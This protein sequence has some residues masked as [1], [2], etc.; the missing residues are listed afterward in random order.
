MPF[1]QLKKK[2]ISY[3]STF[4]SLLTVPLLL[5]CKL[6]RWSGRMVPI[7]M[8]NNCLSSLENSLQN[9]FV[10]FGLTTYGNL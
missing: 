7:A 5:D 6:F 4:F 9:D 8:N 3:D 10:K 1:F 2:Q